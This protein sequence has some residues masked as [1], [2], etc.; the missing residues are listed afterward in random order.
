MTLANMQVYN[1]EIMLNSIELTDQKLDGIA[2]S[3]GG[4][5]AMES[6]S[7]MGDYSKQSFWA[8]LDAAQR[9]VDRYAAN[10]AVANTNLAQSELVGVKVAGGFGPVAFEPGQL[11]WLMKDPGTAIT[12]ISES[13]SN[14]FV[15]DMLNTAVGAGVAAVEN[16]AALVE[17]AGA[18]AIT[19]NVI[20]KSHSLFGDSSAMLI[21]DGMTGDVY[22]RLIDQG[23]DNANTLFRA[24]DV[25]I[26]SILNK[27]VL[28]SDIPA[29]Y[30][31]GSPN[32]DKVL[33]VCAGGIT[34][35]NGNDLITNIDTPNG[36]E[37]LETTWQADYTFGLKLKGY[38]WDTVNGGKS[39]LDAEIFTGSNWDK[40]VTYNKHTLGTL[41]IGSA[42]VAY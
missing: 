3:S 1:E 24:G 34:A 31:A 14:L 36:T 11:T 12:A 22:H 39:P 42:D 33:S 8:N 15:K 16:V 20:N 23:L 40:A 29:L 7:F 5:I 19:Q 41:A 17:D 30:E 38:S 32:K 27:I 10:G 28:V 35:S 13:F 21:T 4:A 2:A 37:R 26:V 9:R 25:T 18:A 6:S